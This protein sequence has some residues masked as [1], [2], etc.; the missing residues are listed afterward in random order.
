[1]SPSKHSEGP[2]KH[3]F[4]QEDRT[5]DSETER[6]SKAYVQDAANEGLIALFSGDQWGCF[7]V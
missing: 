6:K 1:M 3:H 4:Q 2:E 5:T 7:P